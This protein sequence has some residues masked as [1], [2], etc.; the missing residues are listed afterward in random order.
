MPRIPADHAAHPVHISIP[1]RSSGTGFFC[2]TPTAKYIATAAHVLFRNGLELYGP[3]AVLKFVGSDL[4]TP[5]EM[6]LD[7]EKMKEDGNLRK[8]PKADVAVAKI[9]VVT[10]S[11]EKR[12]VN[13]TSGA[14][15]KT[16]L[17]DGT[18]MLGLPSASFRK[19]VD[20]G[21]A[22]ETVMFGYPGKLGL[23]GEIDP[24]RPLLR[25]GIVAGKNSS[26]QI[27]VDCPVYFGNSGALV[28]EIDET[29][30]L[31]KK[32]RGM[33]VVVK[34]VPFVEELWSKQYQTQTS[35][36]YENSG[37]ALV[38]PLDRIEELF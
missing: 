36:R 28:I 9:G 25:A 21:V 35:V 16:A 12:L 7:L 24:D 1:D 29:D 11:E 26:N 32:F 3:E 8:H 13:L 33:G 15:L 6:R 2:N 4:I 17:P 30:P 19:F 34:M 27:V 20:V 18:T 38:E 22:N 37:Y 5:L 23:P 10:K 31:R 14:V